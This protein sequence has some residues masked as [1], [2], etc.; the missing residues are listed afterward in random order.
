MA[1][2]IMRRGPDIGK[3]YQLDEPIVQVGRGK[4]NDIVVDDNE[5]SRE[6]CRFVRSDKHYEIFDLDSSNGTFVNGQRVK[7]SWQLQQSSI[8]ELGDSITFEYKTDEQ[9]AEGVDRPPTMTSKL[10]PLVTQVFLVV[11]VHAQP[12][13]AIYALEDA[14]IT[15]GRAADNK[16]II[17]EPEISR[18]HMKLERTPR[19]YLLTDLGSTNGTI[20]NG[21]MIKEPRLL[22]SGDVIRIGTSIVIQYTNDPDEAVLIKRGTDRLKRRTNQKQTSLLTLPEM[23]ALFD[24]PAPLE[25]TKIDIGVEPEAMTKN[26]L[27][28]Y[29]REDWEK[30]VAPMI[31][32]LFQSGI[33]VWVEQYLMQG[34]EEWR[35]ALERARSECWMLLV[36]VSPEAMQ[37]DYIGKIWRHF[38]NR[39]K[40][41]VLVIARDVERLPIGATKARRILYNTAAPDNT[42]QQ[43]MRTIK[44]FQE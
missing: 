7:E 1:Q 22:V 2:L 24:M 26:V 18:Y 41:V 37:R 10:D 34:S 42:H 38:H 29:A 44:Q 23:T 15:L 9:A 36:V 6:H 32:F 35:V 30:I 5:V 16:V 21:T 33:P 27:V 3:T 4:R 28:L 17:I 19:G 39:E 14:Q 13:R 40:H 31:D 12:N 8:I 25:N 11:T 43:V 20:V